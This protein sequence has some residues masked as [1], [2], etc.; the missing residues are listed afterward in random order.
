MSKT[1]VAIIILDGFGWRNEMMGN[2]VK[3]AKKPN[4]DRY[5][6][7]FPHGNDAGF[8]ICCWTA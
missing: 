6:N 7:N 1:P 2:A 8:R 5:W 4:F 3:L